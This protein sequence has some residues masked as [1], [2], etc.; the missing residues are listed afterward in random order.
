VLEINIG[1]RSRR[2]PVGAIPHPVGWANVQAA[3]AAI[4]PTID[5]QGAC[6]D[7]GL[8]LRTINE[9]CEAWAAG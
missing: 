8:L 5:Q 1:Q 7:V 6:S 9:T 2:S 3:M 4:S